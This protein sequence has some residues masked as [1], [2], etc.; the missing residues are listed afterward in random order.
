MV[1]TQIMHGAG[2]TEDSVRDLLKAEY[3]LLCTGYGLKICFDNWARERKVNVPRGHLNYIFICVQVLTLLTD[4]SFNFEGSIYGCLRS[5][6]ESGGRDI[7]FRHFIA[8]PLLPCGRTDAQIQ[9][10]TG[11]DDIGDAVDD[12]TMAVHAFAHFSL[13]YTQN[14]L[15]LCDLQ[16]LYFNL[17]IFWTHCDI[18]FQVFLTIVEICAL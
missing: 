13:V 1:L 7:P 14:D 11:S 18:K 16:G 4:F 3:K 12:L 6:R 10:F 2:D 8:T 9:K 15:L 5:L 17:M